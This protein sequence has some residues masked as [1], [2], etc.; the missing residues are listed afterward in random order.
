MLVAGQEMLDAARPAH[1]EDAAADH[2]LSGRRRP[3]RATVAARR[4]VAR[5]NRARGPTWRQSVEVLTSRTIIHPSDLDRSLAF[6]GER[7]AWPWPGSSGEGRGRG[8]VFFAGGGLIEV[9]GGATGGS[10]AARRP[11]PAPVRPARVT[12]WL[13]VRS[14]DAAVGRARRR[15]AYPWSAHPPSSRGG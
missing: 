8:V 5:W 14:V 15:G 11:G 10:A 1:G 4:R 3:I 12:L 7:S 9:V 6:Y 13:Q 2:L